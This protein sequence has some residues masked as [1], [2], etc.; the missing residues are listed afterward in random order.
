VN[1]IAHKNQ[2]MK[3]CNIAALALVGWY[4][5]VPPLDQ[6]TP[7]QFWPNVEA[8]VKSWIIVRSYDT[9]FEC[10]N[11]HKMQKNKLEQKYGGGDVAGK[12]VERGKRAEKNLEYAVD[13]GE[14]VG[15][16]IATDDP[17]VKGDK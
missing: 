14:W 2:T 10:T 6:F 3:P 5:I 9:A 11:A 12:L 8:P 16:C 15:Q 17:R 13:A 1:T 4:L 7:S